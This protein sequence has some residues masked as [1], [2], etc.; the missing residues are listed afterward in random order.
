YAQLYLVLPIRWATGCAVLLTV[1]L[2]ARGV[3]RQPSMTPAWLTI[4]A[5]SLLFGA[6]FTLWLRSQAGAQRSAGVLAERTRLAREIHDTLAQGFV[7]V[8]TLLEAAEESL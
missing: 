5:L 4:G 8:V 7:S 3:V 2:V 6:V 1:L